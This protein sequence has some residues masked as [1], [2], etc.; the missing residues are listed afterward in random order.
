[1]ENEHKMSMTPD[2]NPHS[3]LYLPTCKKGKLLNCRWPKTK[4]YSTHA[5]AFPNKGNLS[6]HVPVHECRAPDIIAC[7]STPF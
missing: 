7:T 2:D 3:F 4:P 6:D 5:A 1:M